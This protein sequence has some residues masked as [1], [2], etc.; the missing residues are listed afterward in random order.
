MTDRDEEMVGSAVAYSTHP[1]AVPHPDYETKQAQWPRIN[2]DSVLAR[3]IERV[4]ELREEMSGLRIRIGN[5]ENGLNGPVTGDN[6]V[7]PPPSTPSP[8]G[9]I[10]EL[11]QHIDHIGA[12]LRILSEIAERLQSTLGSYD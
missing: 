6:P 4:R 1:Y 2:G 11:C 5:I 3:V 8:G 7:N 10:G 9:S 12:E